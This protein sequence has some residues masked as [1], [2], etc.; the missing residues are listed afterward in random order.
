M[1][2]LVKET[3]QNAVKARDRIRDYI[4]ETPLLPSQQ[5]GEDL[6]CRLRFKA[7]NFQHTGSFKMRGA[8]SKMTSITGDTGLITASSGNHGIACSRAAA[9]V[10]K[11]LT[12]VLPETVAKPKLAKIQSFGVEVILHGQESGQAE[13]YAQSLAASRGLSYVSPY[14]DPVVIAGQGTIGLELLEQTDQ[15]DNVFISMG[16]GGLIGGVG[17]A[18]KNAN[19][20]TR[21]FGVSAKNSA[22]LAASMSAGEVVET[23]HYDTL[24]D[25]VAG[26]VDADSVTLPLA[27]QVIDEVLICDEAEIVSALQAMAL[28]ENQLVEG[29]A[30]LALAGLFQISERLHGQANVVLLCGANFDSK[31]VMSVISA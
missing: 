6:D 19:P 10:G 24:A 7:E 18:L 5:L 14:N 9:R 3:A 26:G 29:A 25:G 30:A 4:Y 20:G 22:A 8:A 23:D 1:N 21:V 11:N 17:A 28:K 12:V 27:M 13:T 16:G 2:A 15:I 31:N